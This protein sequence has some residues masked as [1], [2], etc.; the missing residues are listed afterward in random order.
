MIVFEKRDRAQRAAVVV[1][2]DAGKFTHTLVVRPRGGRD[3]KPFTF[4]T[5]RADFDRAAQVIAGAAGSALPAEVLVGIEFAGSYGFTLAHYLDQLGYG[6]VS[7]LPAHTKRWKEV[8]HN[9]PLKTDA[10][11]ALGIT[12]LAAQGHFVSFPFLRPAYA[13]LRYLVTARERL[14]VLRRA[15]ITQVRSLLQVVF[16][17]FEE[18]FQHFTKKTP[19]VLLNAFPGPGDL[20]AAPKRK[21]LKVLREASRGHHTTET[22][23]RL[24]AAARGTIALPGAQGALRE[25]IGL[26]LER[27]TLYERHIALLEARM[28]A[29]LAGVEEA[30]FLRSIP[31]LGPLTAAIFLGSIGSPQ[32]YSSSREVLKVAGLSLV[33]RASGILRGQ[34]RI[35]KRGRPLLRQA[36]YLFALRSVKRDGIFRTKFDRL[37]AHN[38]GKKMPAL[39]AVSR[40]ALKVMFQVA[41][42]RRVWTLAAPAATVQEPPS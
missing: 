18:I 9:Q 29:A 16:P 40:T 41:R 38:G 39:V 23:E 26:L 4:Q 21:V 42:D 30:P 19:F 12:D 5:T 17:E 32:A 15:T 22:Y 7:V 3:S 8:A 25:E 36:A 2:V 28:V 13:E 11:D 35:S 14:S 10:K 1:G 20:L 6:V 34:K 24:I 33:E 31:K 37:V 27:F